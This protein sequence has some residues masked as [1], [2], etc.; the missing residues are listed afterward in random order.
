MEITIGSA[1]CD[2]SNPRN[3]EGSGK[4]RTPQG[5]LADRGNLNQINLSHISL[6]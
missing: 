6:D 2:S 1:A 4:P 3:K 5:R